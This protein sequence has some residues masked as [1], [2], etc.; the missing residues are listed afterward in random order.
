MA[1]P[2]GPGGLGL[3]QRVVA[4][5]R[6]CLLGGAIGDARGAPVEF[7]TLAEIRRRF[8]PQGLRD[9]VPACG[10]LGA[11]T[12]DTQMTLFTAEGLICA[13][14]ERRRTGTV[15]HLACVHRAYQ[16][17][18]A[19]QGERPG[20]PLGT[21]GWLL[22]YPALHA[23]RAPGATC[24]SALRTG[25]LGTVDH[26]LKASKGC[27][28]IMRIAPVGLVSREPFPLGCAVAALTHGHPSGYLTAGFFAMVIAQLVAGATLPQ[29][30][31]T[32][33]AVLQTWP[34]HTDVLQAVEAAV[35][36]AAQAPPVPESVERLGEGWVA[37]EM[38]AIAL[39]CALTAESFESGVVLAV[40]HSG[41]SDSTGALTGSLLGTLFGPEA[42]PTCWLAALELRSVLEEVAHALVARFGTVWGEG[43]SDAGG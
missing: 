34:A 18:L 33:R 24:L 25:R 7:L 6:G 15:D 12:D 13:E 10:R 17:W 32:S 38:L 29:A 27:G 5:F 22:R 41:D 4:A 9:F 43:H 35:A 40:N 8:G 3:P 30:I 39:F 11:I 2:D 28:G 26:P 36:L 42:I 23:R 21:E 37:E 19:T 1:G 16:R 14:D 20:G 31:A